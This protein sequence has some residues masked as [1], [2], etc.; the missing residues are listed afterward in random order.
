MAS[1]SDR[2]LKLAKFS[3]IIGFLGLVVCSYYLRGEA[4][5][6]SRI[7]FSADEVRLTHE[8]QEME[9]SYPDR[10]EQYEVELRQYEL[11]Q[12]HY[13]EMLE[14]YQTDYDAY[15]KRI[16]DKYEPPQLPYRPS[17]PGP[18][19]VSRKLYEINADFRKRK[20]AYFRT[21]SKLNW[22]ACVTALMLSGGLLWLMM[23]DT[24]SPRWHYL[25]A[26]VVSFVFLIGPGV[27]LDHHG[28]HR[29]S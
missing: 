21:T 24:S 28:D 10:V 6:L 23:F 18:P 22:L 29:F 11:N 7:R 5:A 26:L 25:V 27:S 2:S 19:E 20:Y 8:L 17:K 13:R 9:E 12:A 16:E 4:L 3:A 14:L 1:A 15:V